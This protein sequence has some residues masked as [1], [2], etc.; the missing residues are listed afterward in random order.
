MNVIKQF[1]TRQMTRAVLAILV[2][3]GAVT[4]QAVAQPLPERV[5]LRP[6]QTPLRDQG[7]RATCIA[8]SSLA[9]LEAAYRRA[10]Y[11]DVRLSVEFAMYMSNLFHLEP[12]GSQGPGNAENKMGSAQYGWS[13]DY[14]KM[15]ARGFAV[16]RE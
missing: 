11:G 2:L 13:I 7:R 14:V 10:G 12:R 3:L 16:P 5:D 6:Q 8:H 15:L 9:A 4:A 1:L